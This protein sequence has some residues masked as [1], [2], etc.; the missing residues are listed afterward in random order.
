MNDLTDDAV[1]ALIAKALWPIAAEW[2][3]AKRQA[4]AKILAWL[5]ARQPLPPC[6]FGFFHADGRPKTMEERRNDR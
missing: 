2:E 4:E 1:R 5:A 3:A 6:S